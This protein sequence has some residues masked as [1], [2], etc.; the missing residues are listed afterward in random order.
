MAEDL[1]QWIESKL[2]TG[3]VVEIIYMGG[4]HPGARRKLVLRT[5]AEKFDVSRL[6]IRA[7]LSLSWWI[8][9]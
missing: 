1:K 8:R 7:S 2:G 9:F 3:E 6:A 5:M 4:S